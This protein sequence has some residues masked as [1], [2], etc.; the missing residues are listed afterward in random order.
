MIAVVKRDLDCLINFHSSIDNSNGCRFHETTL[1][2][3]AKPF[4]SQTD[5]PLATKSSMMAHPAAWNLSKT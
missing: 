2:A 1:R 4:E 3:F 5:S